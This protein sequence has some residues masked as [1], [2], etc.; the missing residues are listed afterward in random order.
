MKWNSFTNTYL[1]HLIFIYGF[2]RKVFKNR[3]INDAIINMNKMIPRIIINNNVWLVQLLWWSLSRCS[4][5]TYCCLYSRRLPIIQLSTAFQFWWFIS[6]NILT[7]IIDWIDPIKTS[8]QSPKRGHP[9]IIKKTIWQITTIKV[10][11]VIFISFSNRL[12]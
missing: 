11:K 8:I 5:I 4:R 7:L 1:P 3:V 9:K 10:Q 12:K 6:S 2:L